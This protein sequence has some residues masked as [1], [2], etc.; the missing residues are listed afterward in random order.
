MKHP[1]P[2]GRGWCKVGSGTKAL[3]VVGWFNKS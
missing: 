3:E 1:G 2:G